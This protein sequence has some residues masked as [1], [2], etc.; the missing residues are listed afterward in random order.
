MP[1]ILLCITRVVEDFETFATIS[2]LPK[3]SS[4][5]C[6]KGVHSSKN[7]TADSQSSSLSAPS[8]Q[9]EA[10]LCLTRRQRLHQ[11][12]LRLRE[13]G[14]GEAGIRLAQNTASLSV[15]TSV[16]S[17]GFDPADETWISTNLARS[18]VRGTR[19]TVG[20]SM[21]VVARRWSGSGD[22]GWARLMEGSGI[23]REGEATIESRCSAHGRSVAAALCAL[24]GHEGSLSYILCG[25]CGSKSRQT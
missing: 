7:E 2:T 16:R 17:R 14:G 18:E 3:T 21:A 19:R 20:S 15:A 22:V 11:W 5:P 1:S 4:F 12:P 13:K 8:F 24:C 10:F 6:A 23:T 25:Q 9:A